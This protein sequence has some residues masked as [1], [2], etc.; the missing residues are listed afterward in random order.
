[1]HKKGWW[2]KTGWWGIGNRR[3]NWCEIY[4]TQPN[5]NCRSYIV[6]LFHYLTYLSI[7]IRKSWTKSSRTRQ[8]MDFHN[9]SSERSAG[10]PSF[11]FISVSRQ[12]YFFYSFIPMAQSLP[13]K[14]ITGLYFMALDQE[15]DITFFLFPISKIQS[16]PVNNVQLG[17]GTH[18]WANG[19]WLWEHC[20]PGRWYL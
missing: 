14:I 19:M 15:T 4:Q 1:M 9:G 3:T 10:C 7:F 12:Q 11:S 20:T 18:L 8:Y 2:S 17:S 13:A 16:W 6:Q 5:V